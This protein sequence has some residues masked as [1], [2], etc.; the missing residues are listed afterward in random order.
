VNNER[1]GMIKEVVVAQFKV[2]AQDLTGG[3]EG[4]HENLSQDSLSLGRDLNSKPPEYEAGVPTTWPRGSMSE[5]ETRCSSPVS[6]V[7]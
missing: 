5:F 3:T 2:L 1:E 7:R 6:I 4:N